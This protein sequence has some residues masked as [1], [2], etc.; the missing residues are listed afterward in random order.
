[1]DYV[2]YLESNKSVLK[3]IPIEAKQTFNP[4]HLKQLS[5]YMSK[6][7]TCVDFKHNI[8]VGVLLMEDMYHL[9]FS[10]YKWNATGNAVPLAY[11]SPSI[12]WRNAQCVSSSGLLLLSL[13]HLIS[14]E[15]IEYSLENPTLKK[16]M[17]A[18]ERDP[19]VAFPK[20]AFISED[21]PY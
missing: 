3:C 21:T 10:P 11:I 15:R 18:L 1:M 8:L 2:I 5:A 20:C 16:V 9:A 17:D 19:Y 7:G 6:L 12:K 13:V 14:K 4:Q